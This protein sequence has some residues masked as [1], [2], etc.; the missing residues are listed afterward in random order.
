MVVDNSKQ[1]VEFANISLL[2]ND[3]IFMYGVASDADGV[4]MLE[5][6]KE[7]GSYALMIS[8][9]G[10][11]KKQISINTETDSL[12]IGI[13]ELNAV[14]HQLSEVV[15]TANR[16]QRNPGGYSVNLQ[17]EDVAKGK[18]ADELLRYLPGITYED[19]S[20]KVLGQNISVIYLDGVRIKNHDELKT[21]PA[22]LMQSAQIDYMA[23][24][25]E[26]ASTK[27]AVIHIKLNKQREEGF[28]GSVTGGA[29]VMTKYGFTDDKF[30]SVFNYRHNKLSL[31]NSLSYN[32]RKAIGD[33]EEW[34]KFKKTFAEVNSTVEFRSWSRNFYNRLSLTY[35]L[36]KNKTF[37]TSLYVSSNK[38]N[39]VNNIAS[40]TLLN[41]TQ[42]NQQSTVET[43][44]RYNL[45]QVTSKFNWITDAKGSEFAVTADYL[46]NNEK[47][48]MRTTL[49]V[50]NSAPDISESHSKQNTDMVE[51]DTY[52]KKVF[53]TDNSLNVG[54]NYRFIRTN[55]DLTNLLS[56]REKSQSLGR[57]PALYSEF[58]GSKNKFQYQIGLRLQQNRIEYKILDTDTK[59]E[60]S[61]WGIFPSA[62]LMYMINGEKG[63]MLMLSYKRSIDDIPYSAISPYKKFSSEYFYTTGNPDLISPK[64]DMLMTVLELFNMFTINGMYMH[65]KGQLY[66]A[67][68]VDP[69]NPLLS[70]TIPKNGSTESIW[71]LGI[72][73]RFT[74]AKWWILKAVA[75]YLS[76]S[77]NTPSYN[78][79]N[80][81]KYYYSV[82]NNFVFSE[83]FGATLE[84]YYEPTFRFTDR[85]YHTVYEARAG[86]YK[87]F[88][89][90][91]LEGRLNAKLFRQ[92]RVLETDTPEFWAS[93]ANKTNEQFFQFSL[94]YFFND[95]KKVNVKRTTGIQDYNKI[96]DL[97]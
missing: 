54:A 88:L 29:T 19:G 60:N 21:I 24:S 31:Y 61:D 50:N 9:I 77:A 49:F 56:V 20:L 83:T 7:T 34:M 90:N 8:C 70:Y 41:D 23:D 74:I 94:T 62:D 66:Y 57:M 84:G 52:F 86:L 65:G 43:P 71:L 96:E 75:H 45:Y 63:H 17:G 91:K 53:G 82:S 10:F 16:I 3:S 28:F 27:G 6:P 78:V 92:G 40:T 14:S 1:P 35:D 4:F 13:I 30:S 11:E 25:R 58:S 5:I 51:A 32:D 15:I 68:E 42:T 39:P 87:K 73:G 64:Q 36:A 85:I 12:N 59:N 26:T 69:K 89:D 2:K 44:Y 22:E 37:G 81:S 95:G 38:A 48:D 46:R 76:Y 72:E 97:K 93:S 55:Y 79:K 18:Q 67:T 33:L 47:D 80:Q